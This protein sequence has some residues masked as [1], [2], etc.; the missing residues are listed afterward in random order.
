MKNK[1]ES[2]RKM[3]R[4]DQNN[5]KEILFGIELHL[6]NQLYLFNTLKKSQPQ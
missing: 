6:N 1:M 2:A 3:N 4:F 5:I